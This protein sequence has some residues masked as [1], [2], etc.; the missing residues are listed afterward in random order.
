MIWAAY[1]ILSNTS[2]V[3]LVFQPVFCSESRKSF[4]VAFLIITVTTKISDSRKPY[5]CRNQN[6]IMW[7]KYLQYI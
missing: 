3:K 4:P 5:T 1:E 7:I 6:Q 2:L